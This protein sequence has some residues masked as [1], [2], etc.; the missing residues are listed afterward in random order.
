MEST[1]KIEEDL[2]TTISYP[3]LKHELTSTTQ[4][5]RLYR[6]MKETGDHN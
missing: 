2:Y 1:K 3:H 5:I 4:E 6:T